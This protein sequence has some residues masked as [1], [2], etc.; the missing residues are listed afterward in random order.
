[1][2]TDDGVDAENYFDL[3]VVGIL[4]NTGVSLTSSVT[5][6]GLLSYFKDLSQGELPLIVA[7]GFFAY[8]LPKL[9]IELNR[10]WLQYQARQEGFEKGFMVS[11][12]DDKSRT[13][14]AL[15]MCD[16]AMYF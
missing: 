8:A 16:R 13:E 15:D 5:M 10:A 3:D 6:A 12:G 1:M 9:L 7:V 2:N 14:K 4:L 11:S